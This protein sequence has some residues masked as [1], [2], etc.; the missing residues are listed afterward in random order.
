MEAFEEY[1]VIAFPY[2]EATKRRDKDQF[3]K[4]L[5][6]EVGRGAIGVTPVMPGGLKSKLKS[7]LVKRA[8][9]PTKVES[10]GLYQKLGTFDGQTRSD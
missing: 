5:E 2:L 6:M 8:S 10:D 1:M 9:P 4:L 3:K 7:R